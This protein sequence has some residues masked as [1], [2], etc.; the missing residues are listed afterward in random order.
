[1]FFNKMNPYC[2]PCIDPKV[3]PLLF[4]DFRRGPQGDIGDQG[5]TG[6]PGITGPQGQTG[7]KGPT[8][9]K[10][11]TGSDGF[12]GN[13]GLPGSRGPQ[14][15][16]PLE[17]IATYYSDYLFWDNNLSKWVVGSE[18][19][20]LGAN[21]GLINQGLNSIAIGEDSGKFNQGGTAIAIG[22][23]AGFTGQGEYSIAIG[24]NSGGGFNYNDAQLKNC[25]AIG[26]F[27]GELGI[28]NTGPTGQYENSIILNAT[29]NPLPSDV[30][31]SFFVAPIRTDNANVN[32]QY[33]LYDICSNEIFYDISFSNVR[34]NFLEINQSGTYNF[35]NAQIVYL[36]AVGGGGGGGGTQYILDISGN[37]INYS[38]LDSI[39]TS[40]GG[41]GEGG[42][43]YKYPIQVLGSNLSFSVAIGQG[44]T[45]GGTLGTTGSIN[46]IP[47]NDN[48]L[49]RNGNATTFTYYISPTETETI[50][51]GGGGGGGYGYIGAS[52][53][54]FICKGGTGGAGGS[55][56]FDNNDVVDASSYSFSPPANN[57]SLF[58][59]A[60]T[61]GLT[62][63]RGTFIFPFILGSS[64]GCAGSKT[65]PM[66]SPSNGFN[67]GDVNNGFKG[68]SGGNT[69]VVN[70]PVLIAP[71]LFPITFPGGGGGAGS[72]FSKG[73]SGNSLFGQDG[74]KGSGGGGGNIAGIPAGKGGNGFVLL[75]W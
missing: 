24:Y 1:M 12:I 42:S 40:G 73:G 47:V 11:N 52:G 9:E 74:V 39:A 59:S 22:N 5:V 16:G 53:D 14:G 43:V 36:T 26:A 30:S 34:Y 7:P 21:S 49:G 64:G 20:T 17:P 3:Y 66:G 33:L 71:E 65:S 19:I 25:I 44:G 62:G 54:K 38:I 29:G 57:V 41:G 4:A 50:Y 48:L 35:P 6:D 28:G 61:T 69:I 13:Q 63:E 51:L 60:I 18:N 68:G 46:S 2:Y 75:E 72:L 55:V 45:G 10:G 8:G 15:F 27:A 58:Q 70:V 31:N 56:S 67:G 32:A 37:S 23:R